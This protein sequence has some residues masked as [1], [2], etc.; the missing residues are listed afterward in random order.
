MIWRCY[1]HFSGWEDRLGSTSC[2]GSLQATFAANITNQVAGQCPAG[3]TLDGC[4]RSQLTFD[5]TS[6]NGT[7]DLGWYIYIDTSYFVLFINSRSFN[8]SNLSTFSNHYY[9]LSI[10]ILRSLHRI[11]II[12]FPWLLHSWRSWAEERRE[13]KSIWSIPWCWITKI[14]LVYPSLVSLVPPWCSG[15]G[16]GILD[17][18]LSLHAKW[19][20]K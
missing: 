13:C 16:V 15:Y 6:C 7:Q 12:I 8:P 14:F 18:K 4:D 17:T 19:K 2:P 10:F 9:L 20:P 5:Y 11:I 3:F 1:I